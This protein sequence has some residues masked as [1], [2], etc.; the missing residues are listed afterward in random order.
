[1]NIDDCMARALVRFA[2]PC[3]GFFQSRSDVSDLPFSHYDMIFDYV[4]CEW[5]AIN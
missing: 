4:P 5:W 3:D 2:R 1:M